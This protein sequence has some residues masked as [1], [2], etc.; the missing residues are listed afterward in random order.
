[1]KHRT[2]EKIRACFPKEH[3]RPRPN[4]E[5]AFELL[6]THA[7]LVLEA[8]TG[9]GKTAIGMTFL[10]SHAGEAVHRFFIVP[11]K[12]IAEQVHTLYGETRI[13]LGRNEHP[14]LYY[15][16]ENLSAADVPCAMLGDCAHRVNRDTGETYIAGV[17]PCP[18]LLQK[19]EAR[20]GKAPVVA[21]FAFYLFS[22]FFAKE[23]EGE[24]AVVV[25]EADALADSVRLALSYEISERTVRRSAGLLAAI[26]PDE[27]RQLRAF[28]DTLKKIVASKPS[29]KQSLLSQE[30]IQ[31]LFSVI[32]AI[33][34]R[35]LVKEI[36]SAVRSSKIDTTAELS[37]LKQVSD[38]ASSIPRYLAS[39]GY[40][41]DGSPES[42]RKALSYIC[43]YWKQDPEDEGK[44]GYK[45]IIRSWAVSGLI[46]KM[47]PKG[48]LLCMSATIGDP[49]MFRFETGIDAPV[50]VLDHALPSHNA[51]VYMP[52]DTPNLAMKN[53][54]GREKHARNAKDRAI[55]QIAE[56]VKFLK[57]YGHRSL[58]VTVSD[59][60]RRATVA[61]LRKQGLE[62][63]TYGIQDDG[64]NLRPKDAAQ[65]FRK[66]MGDA[67]VGTN[68]HFSKGIDLP[69]GNAPVVFVLRPAYPTPDD[70]L[71][72]FQERRLGH[73][74]WALWNHKVTVDALQVRGRN[75]RGPRDKGVTIFVSQQFRRFVFSALPVSLRASYQG[76]KTL[77]QCLKETVVFLK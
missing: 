14:C 37:L 9:T 47:L 58:V 23:W 48:R 67:L 62:V 60:E 72:Q 22:Y 4:Q 21:T 25:D 73:R 57:R 17:K 36:A 33:N 10:G 5:T 59:A 31:K 30:E 35:K 26:A 39:I 18:Y 68:A 69:N 11:S 8:G 15:P 7:S 16:G 32:L 65:I 71:T 61:A 20:K 77:A 28:A 45:L 40:A 1:M 41:R 51:R 2:I 12:A 6:A 76:E 46:S 75:I 42:N 13:V 38:I 19:Y 74:R 70:P 27:A 52:T 56:G 44:F 34:G 24:T 3:K 50:H 55:T 54:T 49:E 66:K 63:V 29:G 43:A 53:R 64:T